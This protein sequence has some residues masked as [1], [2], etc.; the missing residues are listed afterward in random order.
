MLL[1]P[2]ELQELQLECLEEAAW[3]HAQEDDSWND[4]DDE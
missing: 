4:E 3:E 1:S 2:A